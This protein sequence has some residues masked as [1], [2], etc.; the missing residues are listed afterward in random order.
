MTS[1]MKSFNLPWFRAKSI[2]P[3][4]QLIFILF[5]S[6]LVTAVGAWW[7]WG[8]LFFSICNGVIIG[9]VV[10]DGFLL[11]QFPVFTATRQ[12]ESLF[13][14]G[15]ENPVILLLQSSFPISV[16]SWVRDDYPHGFQVNNYTFELAWK[17]ETQKTVRY[18][19]QPHRR[20]R[21]QFRDIHLRVESRL[22]LLL[23][24]QTIPAPA[25]VKVYPRLE[26]V[27]KVRQGFYRRQ[28]MSDGTP[29]A[30]AFGAGREFSHIREYL[31]DDDP[32]NINWSGTARQGKLVSNVYQPEVGQQVAILLDC[33]R[34]MGVQNEGQ[35]QLDRSLEA[36]LGFAAIALQRG[37]RVSFLAFSNKILRWVPLGRGMDHLQHLIEACFDLEPGYVESDY[38]QIWEMISAHHK[39]K[40]LI[41]LFTDA[42]NLAFSETMSP[43]IGRAKKKHL[44]MTVSMQDPR[45]KKLWEQSYH[46][47][48]EIYKRL[49]IEQL[50]SERQQ[51]LRQWGKKVVAL[52]VEPEKLASAVIYS[53]LEI[54]NR[55]ER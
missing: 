11:R 28:S 24:Q 34:M 8:W 14:L 31:P 1:W 25:E 15:E 2:L 10:I 5:L 47:E 17:N 36:A 45:M 52:D 50:Q 48:E 42:A 51:T 26:S 44:V 43:L 29:I 3:S 4:S 21:H 53:Y 37:D 18:H 49:V 40:T 55:A 22:K 27:R 32:R 46:N 54:R 41:T 38:L 39:H 19:A 30:R 12:A 7:G 33:G 35:S 9:L 16:R 23:V 13:E 20:G 6:V